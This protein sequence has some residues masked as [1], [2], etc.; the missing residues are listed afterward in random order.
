MRFKEADSYSIGLNSQ[1]KIMSI[2]NHGL[3]FL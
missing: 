2:K 3:E 1:P